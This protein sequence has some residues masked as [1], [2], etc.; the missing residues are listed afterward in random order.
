VCWLGI[1]YLPVTTRPE[2]IISNMSI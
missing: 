2:I 1:N